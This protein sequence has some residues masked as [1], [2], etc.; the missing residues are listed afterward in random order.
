MIAIQGRIQ[1]R[2][3]EDANG[4]KRSAFEVIANEISFCGS[5][6]DNSA[7]NQNASSLPPAPAYS[8]ADAEDFEEIPEP[9]DDLPF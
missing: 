1:T 4:A 8:T 2:T 5:K 7:H 3:Y 9:E 6:N